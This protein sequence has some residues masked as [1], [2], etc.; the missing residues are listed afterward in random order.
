[1]LALVRVGDEQGLGGAEVL[2][3]EQERL[4][5]ALR[6]ADA[7][8]GGYLRRLLAAAAVEQLLALDRPPVA[9]QVDARRRTEEALLVAVGL[10][11]HLGAQN[12]HHMVVALLQVSIHS[13]F[14]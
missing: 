13:L 3:V 11:R 8:Q 10:L 7:D 12:D 14:G 2:G 5:F 1:M 6:V 9:H 4:H